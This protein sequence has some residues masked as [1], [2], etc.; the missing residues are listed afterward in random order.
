MCGIAG[1]WTSGGCREDESRRLVERMAAVLA[2][3]GPDAC[4]AWVDPHAGVALSHRRLSI[5]D[6]SPAGAQPMVSADG[7]WVITYNGEVY[8]HAELAS[9]LGN[10]TRFRGHSDTEVLLEGIAR[11]GIKK[12][13]EKSVGMFAF[14]AWDSRRRRLYLVRDRL[15]IKPLY[16]A[17]LGSVVLFGSELSALKVHPAFEAEIDRAALAAYFRYCAVPAPLSIYGAVH[18]LEP[19][20]ILTFTDGG[21]DPF[22]ER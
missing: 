16:W 8:N 7:R 19:A 4:G 17:K 20:T 5:V 11:W 3:R 1:F 22:V 2:H 10:S 21:D 12:T 6:L 18:K 13:V 14:A 9:E 15:G